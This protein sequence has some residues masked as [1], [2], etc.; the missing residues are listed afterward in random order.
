MKS[1]L[2]SQG[3]IACILAILSLSDCVGQS[4]KVIIQDT[5]SNHKVR[6]YDDLLEEMSTTLGKGRSNNFTF[7]ISYP[8]Q[9]YIGWER[10]LTPFLLF[11]NDSLIF[12][13][14]AD[15]ISYECVNKPD[16]LFGVLTALEKEVGLELAIHSGYKVQ[17]VLK[18]E[19]EI[20]I[21]SIFNKMHRQLNV[22]SR[23]RDSTNTVLYQATEQEIKCFT[24][25][26]LLSPFIYGNTS[27]KFF[28]TWYADSL[29]K[30]K[31]EIFGLD[32]TV[33]GVEYKRALFSYNQFLC[34]DSLGGKNDFQVQFNSAVRN[35]KG[36]QRNFLMAYILRINKPYNPANFYDNV[37][38]FYNLCKNEYFLKYVKD[39][40]DDKDFV[41]PDYVLKKTLLKDDKS[42]I[43][44]AEL[45]N[46]NKGKLIFIDMWASWCP[47]CLMLMKP[48]NEHIKFYKGKPITFIALSIDKKK[49]AWLKASKR[50][51]VSQEGSGSYWIGQSDKFIQFLLTRR[52]G[53]K[54]PLWIP[55]YIIIDANGNLITVN[56]IQPHIPA[57][58][59]QIDLFLKDVKTD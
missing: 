43:T 56:A 14:R 55:R 53:E 9:V 23:Y 7:N 29:T 3:I 26:E 6:Y 48:L 1:T 42:T 51:E 36:D 11:P 58:R 59:W 47:P 18:S 19:Y 20:L 12:K 4:T 22:L 45:L 46:K 35:F 31:H 28:P 52:I 21:G 39:K 49:Q 8:T 24:L 33:A 37:A 30:F 44:W 32:T 2:F 40:L 50:Y 27:W 15:K 34:R 38:T 25:V 16:S 57:L 41:Y 17:D 13:E 54:M 10:K 5:S